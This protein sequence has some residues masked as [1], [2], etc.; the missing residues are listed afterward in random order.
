MKVNGRRV[1]VKILLKAEKRSEFS[2]KLLNST[3]REYDIDNVEQRFISNLVYGVLEN[4]I[5]IDYKIRK[6]SKARLKKIENEILMILRVSVYQL[7]HMDKVP[8]SAVV[9]E[10]VK[11]AKKVNS[12]FGGFVNGI[13][14]SYI[15]EKDNIPYPSKEKDLVSYLSVIYSHETW[16]IE[17][18]IEQYGEDITTEILMANNEKPHLSIRVNNLKTD[19]GSLKSKLTEKGMLVRNSLLVEDGLIIESLGDNKIHKLDEFNEGLFQI[20]DESSMLVSVIADPKPG[21]FV[22]DVC[23]APGGKTTHMAQIMKNNG[24]VIARDLHEDKLKLVRENA[25]RLGIEIIETQAVDGMIHNREYNEKCDIVI[26]DAPCSNLGIIRRK[27]DVK[28]KKTEAGVV[29]LSK[30]QYSILEN[31]AKYLKKGGKLLY[32]TC[33]IDKIENEEVCQAFLLN[34]PDFTMET[35]E[36]YEKFNKSK[37]KNVLQMIPTVNGTD[38]FYICKMIKKH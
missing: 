2:N 1:A 18:W 29:D 36:G 3:F 12:R 23:A 14:R 34:N 17:K 9:N 35:I 13:L 20:Q 25:V 30:I 21:D 26:V 7:D 19:I 11:M 15:R 6:F 24:R 32:S 10:A 22:M 8:E 38:G 5:N 16:M 28:Y 4:R 37:D 31:S 33:T 27:P